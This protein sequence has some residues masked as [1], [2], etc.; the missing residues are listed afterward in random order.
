METSN[1]R[2]SIQNKRIEDVD[3]FAYLE[4]VVSAK[5]GTEQ[6][7]ERRLGKAMRLFENA[8]RSGH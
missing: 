5:G 7:I 8:K 4:S 6:D 2:L 3:A 1:N